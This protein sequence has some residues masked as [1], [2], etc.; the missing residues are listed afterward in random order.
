MRNSGALQHSN[1]E[2]HIPGREDAA[3]EPP[4]RKFPYCEEREEGE[5]TFI[6]FAS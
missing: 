4:T 1:E 3:T 2:P 5:R 6:D